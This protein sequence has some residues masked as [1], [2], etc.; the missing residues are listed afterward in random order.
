MLKENYD[1]RHS[2]RTLPSP[3]EAQT[4][5]VDTIGHQTLGRISV[6]AGAPRSYCIETP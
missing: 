2:V 5:W 6:A 3:P 1:N 4:V